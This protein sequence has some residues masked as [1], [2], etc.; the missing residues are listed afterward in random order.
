MP[1]ARKRQPEHVGLFCVE[2]DV[3]QRLRI[4]TRASQLALTQ[5][6]W[7]RDKVQ[8]LL[9]NTEVELVRIN[10]KGDR[11]LDVPLAKIGGKGL[12]VKEI[13]EA[14][15][16]GEID[17]AVHSM[18]DVPTVLPKGLHIGIVPQREEA[19]D[20]FVSNRYRNLAELPAG[21]VVGTSSLRRKA[22]LLA[23]RPDLQIRDLRGNVGTRLDKLDRG[24][25]D[26]II[27][28]GAGLKRLHLPARISTLLAPEQMLPAIGQGALG[29]ELRQSDSMLLALMQP[30]HHPESA[31]AVAAERAYLARLEG[32]CQ[33]PIG[34]YAIL[35][36]NQLSLT[37]LI[38]SVDGTTV[39]RQT[40]FAP[41]AEADK[42]GF[43]LAE[44]LLGRGGK[45]ILEAVYQASLS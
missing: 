2:E 32:G 37:G 17:M 21:A 42:L 34:A 11:I 29:I 1:A 24:D 18:K 31:V 14:L 5:S 9:P 23:L 44:E 43:E 27:L 30:L 19:R 7:V 15:L 45:A 12:F 28:A 16:A 39:L 10:T 25:F 13:E 35:S 8:A 33:V 36:E 26:A 41:L 3:I 6:Q 4:G 22:Q 40:R 20:A 38:A